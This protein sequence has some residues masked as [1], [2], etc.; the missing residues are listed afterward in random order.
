MTRLRKLAPLA[1]LLALVTAPG[2]ARAAQ[3][4]A[5]GDSRELAGIAEEQALLRR[6]LERLRNTMTVLLERIEAEGRTHTAE[7]LRG[8]LELLEERSAPEGAAPATVEETMELSRDSIEHGQLVQSLERQEETIAQLER[9][10]SVLM[11]RKNLEALEESIDELKALRE[12]LEDLA[13]RESQLREDTRALQEDSAS[14]GQRALQQQIDALLQAQRAQLQRNEALGRETGTMELELLERELQRLV[15]DQSTDAEVLAAWDPGE[16]AELAQVAQALQEARTAEARAARLRDAA[17]TLR[18][19]ADEVQQAPPG[20]ETT[21]WAETLEKAA[22]REE[23]HERV[24]GDEAA[25]RTAEALRRGAEAVRDTDLASSD[26]G[27]REAT[28]GELRDLA[29]E[30]ERAAQEA[31]APSPE[32]MAATAAGL[33]ELAQR[34]TAGGAVAREAMEAVREAQRAT[35]Q[36]N[37][38]GEAN[39]GAET[40]PSPEG[41]GNDESPPPGAGGEAPPSPERAVERAAAALS[42]A[43]EEHERIGSALSSSQSEAAERAERIQ[44][45][46]GT[47]GESRPASAEEAQSS[48]GEAAQS[49]REAAQAAR[50]GDADQAQESSARALEQLS[51]AA[52]ALG[53][54]RQ[55]AS[56]RTSEGAQAAAQ[57]QGAL[58]EQA[59]GARDQAQEGSLSPEAR[60]T[61]EEAL[62]EAAEAMERA[63]R[64]LSEGKSASAAGSQR[65]AV[66]ALQQAQRASREGVTPS[67]PEDQARAE[68]LA[69][70]QERIR[71]ELLDLAR[72][73]EERRDGQSMPSLSRA[74]Q[75]A[76]EASESLSQGELSEA[77]QAEQDVERELENALEELREEEEA[78]ERLRQEEVLFRIAEETQNMLEVHREQMTAVREI[79]ASRSDGEPSRAQK[80]RLRRVAREEESLAERAD[81]M[82]VAIAN[83]GT[84]VTAELMRGVHDDLLRIGRDLGP[85]GDYR[86]GERVQALQLD[87]EENLEW[88]LEALRDEQQRRQQEQQQQQQQQQNQDQQ[89]KEPLVPD[90]TELKLLRRMEVEVQDAIDRLLIQYPELEDPE[91]VDPLVLEEI[92][93]LAS[94]HERITTLFSGFRERLG[95]PAPGE[96]ATPGEDDG[97]G[98]DGGTS[99][100]GADGEQR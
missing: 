86:T 83:E 19:I 39:E 48:L 71:E 2:V 81:E 57:E 94:R 88:L 98:E 31:R 3:D 68:E 13:G 77:E 60:E 56:E 38:S 11:D 21:P 47:L 61:V 10:L 12:G 93:R 35:A 28:A 15:E 74:S 14:E 41:S 53:V 52:E 90:V 27:P 37:P 96:E 25:G 44:R 85:E 16:E 64:E 18:D 29:D 26:P 78:Y 23:R 50:Q 99:P 22:T 42:R 63:G 72:R 87:V 6:Q 89:G 20:S 79:D 1:L 76:G 4:E 34:D 92:L 70:E 49:M 46:L 73:I 69:A 30:L 24:S 51:E 32:A 82:A 65:Q 75:S 55:Q 67:T 8:G 91:L 54:A 43:Q 9:L 66:D 45:G 58:A 7:L 36:A 40:S 84:D 5:A 59:E 95:L 80:L 17:A 97:P 62:A 100:D 33:E